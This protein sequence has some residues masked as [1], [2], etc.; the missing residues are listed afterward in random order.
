MKSVHTQI[1]LSKGYV[2]SNPNTLVKHGRENLQEK[3]RILLKCYIIHVIK[4]TY[5]FIILIILPN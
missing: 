5:Y 2:K 3:H 4:V 1:I